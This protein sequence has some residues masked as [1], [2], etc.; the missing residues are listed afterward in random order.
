MAATAA[1]ALVTSC[2]AVA[3]T[4]KEIVFVGCP[5]LRNTSLPCWLGESKGELYYLGPQGDLGAPFYPPE[6]DH[7][8][9][10]E[11]VVSDQRICGG[12]VLKPVKVSILPEVDVTCNVTL[13]AMGFADP[14]HVRG[15]GPSGERGVAPAPYPR[16]TLATYT[17]P[18]KTQTFDAPFD[19][20]SVR[21]WAP[22][23]TAILN[24]ARYANA[25]KARSIH[26]TGYR[27]AFKL[28]DGGEFSEPADLAEQRARFV[29]QAL[30]TLDLPE[31]IKITSD[32]HQ[33][34]VHVQ[35][36]EADAAARKVSIVVTP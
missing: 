25:A 36:M 5:V 35:G 8:M 12:L 4:T 3:S 21:P 14:P 18:F 30:H 19:A 6:F 11:G 34:A 26:V 16:P 23:Q 13:P 1:V 10:V 15:P 9:L 2:L 27:A 28:S 29:E 31:N 24:A 32:W 20:G 22:A 33:A 7:Q 17:A